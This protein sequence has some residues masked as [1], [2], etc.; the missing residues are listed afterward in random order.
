M[1]LVN[2]T[3]TLLVAPHQL[4]RMD[5]SE[6]LAVAR[7]HAGRGAVDAWQRGWGGKPRRSAGSAFPWP[8]AGRISSSRCFTDFLDAA[9]Q[10][11]ASGYGLARIGAGLQIAALANVKYA[12]ASGEDHFF[13][14]HR[15]RQWNERERAWIGRERKRGKLADLNALLR[16]GDMSAFAL[17][18]G[19]TGVLGN[20]RYVITLD[21]DTQL[22]R[23]AGWRSSS[24]GTL[25][26]PLNRARWDESSGRVDSGY[27][28]L[29]PR[30]WREPFRARSVRCLHAGSVANLVSIPTR[31]PS[32]TC[33]RTCS[34]KARSSAKA[35]T[36]SR[37]SSVHWADV[38]RTTRS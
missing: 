4:P 37:H 15:P 28:I 11:F 9:Q 19:D 26:H 8:I 13:L 21:T 2:W 25:A 20:V 5:Y 12:D 30:I 17:I 36:T 27:G 23:D 3:A 34:A 29:Q 38:F 32:P 24:S 33:T 22:P 14:L 35:C 18:E 10:T 16:K 1:A 6:G 31:K 7:S